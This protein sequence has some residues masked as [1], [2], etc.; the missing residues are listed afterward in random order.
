VILKNLHVSHSSIDEKL[1]VKDHIHSWRRSWRP[2][3]AS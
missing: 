3:S 1:K 2:N